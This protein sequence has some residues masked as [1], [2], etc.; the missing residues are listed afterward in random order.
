MR[1]IFL[2]LYTLM[3]I[4]S[5]SYSQKIS[6][7]YQQGLGNYQMV[8]L[9]KFNKLVLE[10]MPI[11]PKLTENFPMYFY[12]QGEIS[13]FF[14]EKFGAG[15]V[16]SLHSSGARISQKDYS[17]EYLLDEIISSESYGFKLKLR[18]DTIQKFNIQFYSEI[19]LIKSKFKVDEYFELYG[20]SVSESYKLNS[21]SYYIEP[22]FQISYPYK[23]FELGANIGYTF[24][25]AKKDFTT[26]SGYSQL[27]LD[28]SSDEKAKADWEGFRLGLFLRFNLF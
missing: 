11:S 16:Y 10:N 24:D 3:L 1:K 23:M 2:L 14:T 6:I 4:S 20:E 12:Y 22:G 8:D 25:F 13:S 17:G 9:K 7:E 18:A 5:I 27:P 19:G 28:I 15:I 21:K 26:E